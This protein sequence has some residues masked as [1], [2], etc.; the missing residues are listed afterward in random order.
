[1]KTTP[2]ALTAFFC[3]FLGVFAIFGLRPEAQGPPPTT[4][5]L[6]IHMVGLGSP[7]ATGAVG[8]NGFGVC[9]SANASSCIYTIPL[10]STVRLT[11]NQPAGSTPAVLTNGSGSAA[12]C[13]T[14]TCEFQ[15]T[16]NSVITAVFD[17]NAPTLTM[18]VNLA[19]TGV[20]EVG[21]DNNLCQNFD[22]NLA[23]LP[24]QFSACATSYAPQSRV[25]LGVR[26]PAGSRFVGFSNG[27][28]N[29]AVCA[30]PPCSFI[31]AANTSVDATFRKLTS[32]AV[33]PAIETV[34]INQQ[35]PLTAIGTYDDGATVPVVGFPI[36]RTRTS[37][38]T[39]RYS[40]AAAAANGRIYAIGGSTSSGPIA[41]VEEYNPATNTW[42]PRAPM[43]EQRAAI[44]AA[45]IDGLVYVAGGS[46][47]GN[48]PLNTLEIY[49]PVLDSWMAGPLMPGGPRKNAVVVAVGR[50]IYVIGGE[51]NVCGSPT[52]AV[53]NRVEAFDVDTQ[54]WSLPGTL[55]NMPTARRFFG[56]GA[57]QGIIY[58][59]GGDN[60]TSN[61][62]TVEAYN[63]ATNTWNSR[64]PLPAARSLLA[65]TVIDDALYA[66][67]GNN[68]IYF[69]DVFVFDAASNGWQRK[70]QLPTL[71]EASQQPGLFLTI[72]AQRAEHAM[73]TLGGKMYSLGGLLNPG[74]NY[75]P[76]V[77]EWTDNLTWASGNAS[78]GK[79]SQNGAATGVSQG[80]VPATA[81]AGGISCSDPG[82]QCGTL[83]V[84]NV[85]TSSNPVVTIFGGPATVTAG[86]SLNR[87]GNFNDPDN[88]PWT[89]TVNYGDNTGTQPLPLG[90]GGPGSPTGTFSLSHQYTQVG[91][92][93]LTVRV[94]D[95]TGA[96]GVASILVSV[97]PGAQ[98]F[99]NTPNTAFAEVGGANWG[100]GT[101]LDTNAG[102]GSWSATINYGDGSGVQPLPL[103][104]PAPPS[105][106][107]IGGPQPPTGLFLFNHAYANEGSYQV[108]VTV[109]NTAQNRTGSRTFT[110]NV[111]QP[112]CAQVT[113]SI[114]GSSLPFNQLL[115]DVTRNGQPDGGGGV[116][117]GTNTLDIEPG[118][119]HVVFSVPP[120]FPDYVVVPSTFD[121]TLS[122]GGAV[123]LAMEVKRL[124][125]TAPV[126]SSVTP[127]IGSL[128]PPN[129]KMVGV[130]IAAVATDNS[131][132]APVCSIASV[133][134]N[135]PINGTGDGDTGPDWDITGPLSVN[136]R[137]ERAGGGSG[138]VYT[139]TVTC[140]DAAN[141]SA[142]AATQVVVP[143][144]QGKK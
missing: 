112:A 140:V 104:V 101:F 95:S 130:T 83:N 41:T 2:R 132:Q 122:C 44:G 29:A 49:N 55:T 137:A 56:A 87:S 34:D 90:P 118:S 114:A 5:T 113:L 123:T 142:S 33:S 31:L 124:D 77:S 22:H 16:Q 12:G 79:I 96:V 121:F 68:G 85:V 37:M 14:S 8:T 39:A 11:G 81:R 136:L 78:I 93:T 116:P 50:K 32:V 72:G 107:C 67:G 24:T 71:L 106:P 100:C 110:V 46:G 139:A 80:T 35:K 115:V 53:L 61:L 47:P 15:I 135:E 69:N 19:G 82:G 143:H 23:Q 75:V 10:N 127:S 28:G 108:T 92:Y 52:G 65:V 144:S 43:L 21:A 97:N 7:P 40:F 125:T 138:R 26:P 6:T 30:T 86:S 134:S 117:I 36:W 59:V 102:G 66:V 18:Q 94:T 63:P 131:G 133:S 48:C 73:A 4:V 20:G 76:Y 103:T 54:Q 84:T 38:P 105:G 70:G 99:V 98:I 128:W 27:T 88:G 13:A 57:V 109:T 120:G 60:T 58:A 62:Q 74:G 111:D 17:P 51:L 1:M 89:A 45:S 91:N 64:S 3:V 42:T 141:N 119:Y 9:N 126:I 129:H 25:T